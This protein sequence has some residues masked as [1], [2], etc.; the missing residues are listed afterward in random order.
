MGG[1]ASISLANLQT[2][3]NTEYV[4]EVRNLNRIVVA[5]QVLWLQITVEIILLV[6]VCESLQRLVHDVADDVLG[7]QLFP[8]FHQLVD[9]Q[10]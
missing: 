1:L 3:S 9:I 7:E 4:P 5:Q 8:L 6:H 2:I 10:I